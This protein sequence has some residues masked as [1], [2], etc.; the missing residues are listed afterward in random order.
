MAPCVAAALMAAA[1]TPGNGT[2]PA[3]PV[4][5]MSEAA[6]LHEARPEGTVWTAVG[7]VAALEPASGQVEI[8]IT[9]GARNEAAARGHRATF[10]ATPEQLSGLRRGDRVEF[11][12]VE[13]RPHRRMVWIV[14]HAH[15]GPLG[16]SHR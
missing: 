6:Q 5:A 1:C 4:D 3:V 9:Q 7:V 2:G 13:S 8:I 15:G 12:F 16:V 10:L 14:A 11:R